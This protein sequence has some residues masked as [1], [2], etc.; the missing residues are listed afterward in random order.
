MKCIT[1]G[2]NNEA[3]K[4]RKICWKCKSRKVKIDNPYFYYYNLLRSNSKYRGKQ[5]DLTLDEFKEFC[6]KTGYLKLKGKLSNDYSID[7]IDVNKGYSVDNIRLV[8]VSQNSKL[9]KGSLENWMIEDNKNPP[10]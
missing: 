5:F 7:R 9:N 1:Y 6:N 2:C 10:F 3:P 8:T 4:G